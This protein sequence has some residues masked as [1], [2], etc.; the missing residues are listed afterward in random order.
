MIRLGQPFSTGARDA[1]LW[2]Q[3]LAETGLIA[4]LVIDYPGRMIYVTE[5]LIADSGRSASEWYD[6]ALVNMQKRTPDDALEEVDPDSGLL[7]CG[8]GDAYDSSRALLLDRLLPGHEENGFFVG[9]PCRDQLLVL[10]VSGPAL[11]AVPL[12]KTLVAK[13]YK[14]FPYPI[15]E[16]LF[17][18]RSGVWHRFSIEFDGNKV[19]IQPPEEFSEVLDRL[20]P[21]EMDEDE[22]KEEGD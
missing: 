7:A 9:L 15:S 2:S 5:Q 16:E 20:A 8:V 1:L 14:G 11:V 17:W 19:T 3:P 18:V 4:N 12:L 22:E 10:P 6:R 21:D 13:N